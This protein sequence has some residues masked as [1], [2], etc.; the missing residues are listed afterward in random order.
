MMSKKDRASHNNSCYWSADGTH[1]PEIQP[2]TKIKHQVLGDY[3]QRWVETLTG[4][5]KYGVRT[6]TLVDGFCGGGMYTDGNQLWEGSSLRMIRKVE[7]GLRNV[8][9]R[10]PYQELDVKFIFIDNDPDHTA[11]LNLQLKNAGFENYIESGKCEII[12]GNFHEKLDYCLHR[13]IERKG[14]S[15]FFLDPFGLDITPEIVKKI[16]DLGRSEVLFNHMLFVSDSQQLSLFDR[17]IG[18]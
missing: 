8:Q 3:T 18:D 10:K 9:E 13:I 14:H 4:H 6:V 12:T 7:E 1:L 2:H 16:I 5:G 17:L 11:C 15:F